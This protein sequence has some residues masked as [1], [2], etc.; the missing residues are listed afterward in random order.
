M[1]INLKDKTILI[2]G[3][4]GAISEY[5]VNTLIDSGAFLILTDRLSEE[6]AY[7]QIKLR[8][9]RP[10][11]CT[12]RVMDVT[13][14]GATTRTVDALFEEYPEI[15]IA[16]GHA[17]GTGMELFRDSSTESFDE[18]LDFNFKGQVYFTR[19][20]LKQWLDRKIKGHMIY[21]SSYV[22][23]LPWKGISAYSASKAALDMFAKN[24]ALEYAP[25]GIRFNIVSPGNVAAGS[26]QLVYDTDPD[27]RREVDKISPLGHR[28]TPQAIANGFLYLCSCLADE[29]DGHNLSID[30]GVSL[31]KVQG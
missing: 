13:D 2:T 6:A 27:Y 30:A 16:L 9:H 29:L 25:D 12:Y 15:N 14:S 31:P 20:V 22:S 26:S 23:Q 4:F 17:G 1:T 19:P 3:A 21:T 7:E 11:S 5:I 28:N 8:G 24:M 10:Q 18:V